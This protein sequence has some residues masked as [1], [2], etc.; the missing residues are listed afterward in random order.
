MFAAAAQRTALA[1]ATL[2]ALTGLVAVGSAGG[3]RGDRDREA[4]TPPGDVHVVAA[5]QS[6]VSVAWDPSQDNVGVAGYLV[7]ADGGRYRVSSTAFTVQNTDC[8]QS[9]AVAVVA[10][11]A[12]NN[13]SE[14]SWTIVSTAPCSDLQPPS[15]PSGFRQ[16]ATTQSSAVVEWDPSTDNVGVVS[17]GVY[18]G[19][20][21]V[22]AT[23][24]PNA[25][26]VGLACGSSTQFQVDAADAAGN[27][28]QRS[29]VWV[30]AADC[31]DGQA[32]STPTDLQVTDRSQTGVSLA[33]SASTDNVAVVE[34]RVSVGNASTSV[35]QPAATVGGLTCGTTYSFAVDASDAAGNRSASA[36]LSAATAACSDPPPPPPPPP[37]EWTVCATEGQLCTFTGSKDVRYGA[38]GTYTAPRTFTAPVQCSNTVFGDPVPGTTK[39]CETRPA[40]STPPPPVDTTPPT[41]PTNLAVAAASASTV[42]LTWAAATDNVGVAGY[43][44]F[45]NGARSLTVAQLAAVL[46]SL[47]CGT[48]Y[49]LGL[50]A[51][52]RAG[53]RSR[54]ASVIA[55][56][57]PCVDT[58][59]PSAPQSVTATSRTET[60]I[61]LSWLPSNDN[62]GVTAYGLHRGGVYQSAVSGTTGLYSGLTCNTNYTLAVDAR[63]AA[64]NVSGRTTVM[65]ATAACPDTTPPSAPTGV[66][67]SNVTQTDLRLSWNASTDNLDVTG[68]DVYRNGSKVASA[69]TTSVNQTGLTCG[70]TYAFG[71]VARDAAGNSSAAA[72]RSFSTAACSTPPPPPSE[73]TVCATEGQQCTFTT[74]KDVR[75]GANG[76]YTA[77]RAFAASVSCSNSVFGDPV[78]GTTKRCETRPATS[79]PP[80]P[81]PPPTGGNAL[82][83]FTDFRNNAWTETFLN[84]WAP[85]A[86]SWTALGYAGPAWSDGSGIYEISTPHGRGFRFAQYDAVPRGSGNGVQI[87]DVDSI[88]DQQNFLGTVTRLSGKIMFPRAGNPNGFPAY[89]DWNVLWEW[90]QSN[91][92]DNGFGVDALAPG[93]PTLYVTTFNPAN[94]GSDRKARASSPLV[95]DRWYD[96]R[97]EI[98]WSQGSDGFMNFW[99]DGQQVAAF[100]GPTSN[101]TASAPYL[102]WGWYGGST[103]G[104]NEVQYAGLTTS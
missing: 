53:N 88:V 16:T 91:T 3:S 8:G 55:S 14:L 31:S 46:S 69:T 104:R 9:I 77:P 43:D 41:S 4:P 52:D 45:A 75:Y 92:V 87:A 60:S 98:K 15:V 51:F 67:A 18:R 101:P 85:P 79:T 12:A 44:V 83:D 11:D 20:Q 54:R 1:A 86:K 33:W 13:R 22:S 36:T 100:T 99:L 2:I 89:G 28:S 90:G 95:Y 65:A 102:Q 62:V 96:W 30:T 47:T 23:A 40:S 103:P 10:Y 48:G 27:R 58:Q 74:P 34:Y 97:W 6:S 78:P 70:T 24:S 37:S 5:T 80:P 73:W 94:P 38:N 42:S 61:A 93:G 29:S 25:A 57:A 26:L 35:R 68:Y 49:Q 82:D 32:P 59:A 21:L 84:R 19:P 63:D 66:A 56:T 81:P 71:V 64:G 76:I 39:R 72:Q 7:Y 50:E 17:Y